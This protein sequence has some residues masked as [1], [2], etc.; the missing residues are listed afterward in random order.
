MSI[1]TI[2]LA[3]ACQFLMV[4]GQILLKHAMTGQEAN[5]MATENAKSSKWRWH[6]AGAILLQALWFFTWSGLLRNSDL[7][8]LYPFEGLN[9]VLM[10]IAVWIIFKEKLPIGAWIGLI[11]VGTGIAL[12]AST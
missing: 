10:C 8:K 9:P 4:G 1:V 6:F 7:S 12:V 2:I 11:F 5:A 3:I